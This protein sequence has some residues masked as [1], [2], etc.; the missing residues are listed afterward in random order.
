MGAGLDVLALLPIQQGDAMQ[1]KKP[2][3]T[4]ATK[5]VI[6]FLFALQDS[7]TTNM[8]HAPVV[9]EKTYGFNRKQ[10]TAVYDYWADNYG[11]LENENQST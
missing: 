11:E 10:S 5:K 9:L 7:G 8:F 2:R 1:E 4:E 6:R 3:P